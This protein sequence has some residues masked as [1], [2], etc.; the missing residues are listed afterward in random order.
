MPFNYVL[1]VTKCQ[2]ALDAAAAVTAQIMAENSQLTKELQD[3]INLNNQHQHHHNHFQ[4]QQP[5]QIVNSLPNHFYPPAPQTLPNILDSGAYDQPPTAPEIN[6]MV[7]APNKNNLPKNDLHNNLL[8]LPTSVPKAENLLVSQETRAYR[9]RPSN[10]NHKQISFNKLNS[11]QH[12]FHLRGFTDENPD[13]NQ[14]IIKPYQLSHKSTATNSVHQHSP[15]QSPHYFSSQQHFATSASS[16]FFNNLRPPYILHTGDIYVAYFDCIDQNTLNVEQTSPLVQS[17]MSGMLLFEI[18]F[19]KKFNLIFSY[20]LNKAVWAAHRLNQV[21]LTTSQMGIKL[22]VYYFDICNY[23]QNEMKESLDF[24]SNTVDS[25]HQSDQIQSGSNQ[26]LT[27]SDEQ[28][29]NYLKLIEYNSLNNWSSNNRGNGLGVIPKTGVRSYQRNGKQQ[30]HKMKNVIGILVDVSRLHPNSVFKLNK[31][32]LPVININ[33][34]PDY[35]GW[36]AEPGVS[37]GKYI[38]HS[39]FL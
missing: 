1:S 24:R 21:N 19:L 39:F 35:S 22:G 26:K 9:A 38:Y 8:I 27:A 6:Q 20:F 37:L 25:I 29:E 33:Q 16:S 28:I 12:Q 4:F 14:F 13:R 34:L 15:N 32:D 36:P 30:I 3:R 18:F 10:Q 2:K 7:G 17:A 5:P 31:M 11:P 23:N